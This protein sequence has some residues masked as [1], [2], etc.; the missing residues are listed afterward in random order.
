MHLRLLGSVTG[1]L[2]RNNI[3][4]KDDGTALPFRGAHSILNLSDVE[5][6]EFWTE[7]D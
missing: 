2:D 4:K 3:K 5:L 7:N 6:G 1:P